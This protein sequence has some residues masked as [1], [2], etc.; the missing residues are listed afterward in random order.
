MKKQRKSC[1]DYFFNLLL[2]TRSQS[3][4]P[5]IFLTKLNP[6]LTNSYFYDELFLILLTYRKFIIIIEKRI[7]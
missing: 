3:L 4:Q 6:K 1:L 7:I 2:F 5:F